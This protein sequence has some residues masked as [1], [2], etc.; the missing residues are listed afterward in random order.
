MEVNSTMPK[1]GSPAPDFNL[2]EVTVFT[3]ACMPDIFLFDK[4]RKLVYRGQLDGS[5]PGN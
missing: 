3:A 2:P 1:L 4:E 5:R